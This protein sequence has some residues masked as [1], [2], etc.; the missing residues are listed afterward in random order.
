MEHSSVQNYTPVSAK[1]RGSIKVKLLFALSG[2]AM[3]LLLS[4]GGSLLFICVGVF[5]SLVVC[6][7]LAFRFDLPRTA[8]A[9]PR[10]LA[11]IPGVVLAGYAALLYRA[12]FAVT[13]EEVIVPFLAASRLSF[14]ADAASAALPTLVCVCALFA[15]FVW[16]YLFCD[17]A[18]RFTRRWLAGSCRAERLFLMIGFAVAVV[19]IALVY[20][21]TTAFYGGAPY[22]VVYTTDSGNL[23]S[24]NSYLY[25][26]AYENDLRQPMFAVFSMPFAAVAMLLSKLLFFVP[27][28]YA[29]VLACVQAL[30]LLFAFT[31][32]ARM[33]RLAG[34]DRVLFLL[35]LAVSYPTL[36]FA[37]AFEQYAFSVFWVIV[38]LYAWQEKEEPR[39]MLF[40]AATGSLLASGAFFPLLFGEK[41]IKK[42][43]RALITAGLAFV[44]VFVLFGRV[45]LLN[46]AAENT[47]DLISFA[48]GASFGARA[49]QYLAFV[50]ACFAR[51][52]AGI[53]LATY[54]HASYQM[55]AASEV[56][57]LGLA[58]LLLALLSAV[59]HRKEAHM[60]V[61]SLWAGFS[62]VL[63]LVVGWGAS[64]NGMVLYTLYFFWAFAALLYMLLQRALS[65]KPILR[66]GVAALALAVLACVNT[67][68]LIDLIRFGMLYYPVA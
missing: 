68:G 30:L 10:P 7:I 42:R 40:V 41:G 36:L 14:L 44:A 48:G 38:F 17:W 49:M 57:W 34:A 60:R 9:S 25:V 55:L 61:F 18:A 1:K 47:R 35:L 62:V 26:N 64:E 16:F 19:A 4:Q 52:A 24:T 29:L 50:S 15:L 33:L 2:A 53:D 51:P 27:Y 37:F 45:P 65:T 32:L 28:A 54:P 56:N 67:F 3:T 11:L 12:V 59:L 31:L 66:I 39:T 58:L 22:D 46:R 63:L 5:L 8:L 6:L 13:A 20:G 43:F 23:I 21:R